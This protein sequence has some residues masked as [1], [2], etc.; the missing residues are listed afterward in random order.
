M[1]TREF[2]LRMQMPGIIANG[3]Q[4]GGIAKTEGHIQTSS[5]ALLAGLRVGFIDADRT[6]EAISIAVDPHRHRILKLNNEPDFVQTAEQ[7]FNGYD[8]VLVDFGAAQIS[9]PETILPTLA[10]MDAFGG[11]DNC[12]LVLNQIPH[13]AGLENDLKRIA[14]FFA[15]RAQIRVAQVNIN[16]TGKFGS[17][18]EELGFY[19]THYVPQMSPDLADLWRSRKLLPSDLI[20]EP[21]ADYGLAVAKIAE[22]L[23]QIAE[24]NGYAAWLGAAAAVPK[25]REAA[26]SALPDVP[27]VPAERLTDGAI[28]EYNGTTR[29]IDDLFTAVSDADCVSV[30]RR[31]QRHY[32][33]YVATIA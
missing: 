4:A 17:L 19:P 3:P 16:G 25:L 20:L 9:D 26:R 14:G 10:L 29:A 12:A 28:R 11:R 18:P 6:T 13:K 27:S 30:V 33:A 5:I 1:V 21:P 23:L 31:A 32:N 8:L 22:H 24:S 2:R 7:A 15:P